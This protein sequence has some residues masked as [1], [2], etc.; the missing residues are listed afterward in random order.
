M[1]SPATRANSWSWAT[2][3]SWGDR[4]TQTTT[5]TAASTMVDR[6]VGDARCVV[7]EPKR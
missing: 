3:K 4:P 5:T 1:L 2:A 6:D 7:I